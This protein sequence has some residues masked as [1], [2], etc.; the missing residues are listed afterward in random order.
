MA[1]T[2]QGMEQRDWKAVH[3]Y[4]RISPQKA[5]LIMGM[6]RGMPCD[7][8]MDVLNFSHQRSAML[9]KNVLRSA[10]VN[11]DEQEADMRPSGGVGGAGGRRSVFPP[12]S[13]ERSWPGPSHRQ[14]HQSPHRESGGAINRLAGR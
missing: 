10:M 4:A 6:I 1:D 11:A 7:V 3:R 5:R 12:V 9:I 2:I 14:A 8:A 13:A